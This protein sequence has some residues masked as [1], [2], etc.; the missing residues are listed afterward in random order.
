MQRRW[1]ARSAIRDSALQQSYIFI[2]QSIKIAST[3]Y[4]SKLWVAGYWTTK[5][6]TSYW[7]TLL[8]DINSFSRE[9]YIRQFWDCPVFL[10]VESG[11]FCAMLNKLELTT[12]STKSKWGFFRA[13]EVWG[14]S[15]KTLNFSLFWKTFTLM[16]AFCDQRPA[17]CAKLF[18]QYYFAMEST[19]KLK[20]QTFISD[21]L[22][23]LILFLCA[24]FH[25][26]YFRLIFVSARFR[27]NFQSNFHIVRSLCFS[28]A[29]L[30]HGRF[31]I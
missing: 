1:S 2:L 23:R 27:E 13:G 26:K 7:I 16:A 31:W 11:G 9:R 6:F 12:I 5:V 14:L 4:G 10:K 22:M 20:F 19:L 15:L 18:E 25:L 21:I 8:A 30:R 24:S 28:L 29:S 17:F 3:T